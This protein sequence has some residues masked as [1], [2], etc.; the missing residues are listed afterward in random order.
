MQTRDI[1]EVKQIWIDES[2]KDGIVARNVIERAAPG[3]AISFTDRP[4]EILNDFRKAGRIEDKHTLL[5]YKFPGKFLSSCPGSDGMVCCNYFVINFGYGCLYDCH[6]CFLQNYLN[7]PL[8]TLFGNSDDLF[9]ELG[10]RMQN[11][12]FHFR[13]GTGETTDSLVLEPLSGMAE[14]L[15]KHFAEIPNATLELKTKSSNVD[16]LLNLDHRGRTVVSWSINPPHIAEEIEVGTTTIDQRLEAARK[17]AKAG[18]RLAFHLDPVIHFEGWESAY[19]AL[20]DRVF[21]TVS[22]DSV[23]WISLGSFRYTPGLK[24]VMQSRFPEDWLTRGEMIQGPDGK[25]RYFKTI[26]EEMYRSI[27]EKIQS[28]DKRLFLYLC[29]ETRRMWEDVFHF[30]PESAKNLDIGFEERRVY[31]DSLRP[32]GAG[33]SR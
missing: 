15:V 1:S 31:L 12:K 13:V 21:A 25:Y 2:V 18:Y 7:N 5:V 29:M 23:A 28:V 6:Y 8:I 17:V 3:V 19:H 24:T 14:L 32:S 22:P 4:Q 33:A 16:T 20:I 26:R 11:Q 9:A 30:V 10:R 27:R